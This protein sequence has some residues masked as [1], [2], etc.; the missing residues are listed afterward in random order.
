VA[1]ESNKQAIFTAMRE[2][3]ENYDSE[4]AAEAAKQAVDS[5]ID[6]LEAVEKGTVLTLTESG[7][8]DTPEGLAM[9][10]ECAS[11]WGEAITLLKF[12]MEHGV[13]YNSAVTAQ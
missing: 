6:L 3:I 8:K 10:L 1:A 2:A 12:Y 7:Y 11:G 13:V 4:A 9:I 5:G